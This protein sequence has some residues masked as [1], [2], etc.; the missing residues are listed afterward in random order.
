MSNPIDRRGPVKGKGK[1]YRPLTQHLIKQVVLWSHGRITVL[2]YDDKALP[3]LEGD[4]GDRACFSRILEF[5]DNGTCWKIGD[6]YE[7][8]VTTSRQ[9]LYAFWVS[10]HNRDQRNSGIF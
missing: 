2:G 6:K 1:G 4:F 3:G 9:A 5:A 7:G 8:T 10:V